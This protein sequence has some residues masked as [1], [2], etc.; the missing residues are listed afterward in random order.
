MEWYILSNDTGTILGVYGSALGDMA[1]K[2][3]QDIAEDTGCPMA[4]HFIFNSK[5]PSVGMSISM[6]GNLEWFNAIHLLKTRGGIACDQFNGQA[7][8][9]INLVTCKKCLKEH[10]NG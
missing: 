1:R 7:H 6:K 10:S 4:L 3:G 9:D 5:K 8:P 2:R